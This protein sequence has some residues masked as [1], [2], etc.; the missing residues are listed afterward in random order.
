MP[1]ISPTE[2]FG[3]QAKKIFF[4]VARAPKEWSEFQ[5]KQ[6]LALYDKYYFDKQSPEQKKVLRKVRP[7]IEKRAKALGWVATGVEVAAVA[8]AAV[9]GF[10]RLKKGKLAT[11]VAAPIASGTPI[12]L[13]NIATGETLIQHKTARIKQ[14][15]IKEVVKKRLPEQIDAFTFVTDPFALIAKAR[16]EYIPPGGGISTNMRMHPERTETV[17]LT[18]ADGSYGPFVDKMRQREEFE[19]V[20]SDVIGVEMPR[21]LKVSDKEYHVERC[22]GYTLDKAGKG[23]K[24]GPDEGF[25]AIPMYDRVRGM[26]ALVRGI[27]AAH[28]SGHYISDVNGIALLPDGNIQFLDTSWLTEK[29]SSRDFWQSETGPNGSL[30]EVFRQFIWR[31]NPKAAEHIQVPFLNFMIDNAHKFDTAG[32]FG[33][34]FNAYTLAKLNPFAEGQAVNFSRPNANMQGMQGHEAG[35]DWGLLKPM[36]KAVWIA[37]HPKIPIYSIPVEERIAHAQAMTIGDLEAKYADMM[38]KR[39]GLTR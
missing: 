10:Q 19:Q 2:A 4:G 9:W 35:F 11:P 37:E 38:A 26:R 6:F 33:L 27:G 39:E 31:N 1:E 36:Y 17:I 24:Q 5:G 25:F 18:P 8:S 20:M 12:T 15:P 21:T 22:R 30:K 28:L 3:A 7:I 16:K 14:V 13:Q 23:F 32:M 34:A 29:G